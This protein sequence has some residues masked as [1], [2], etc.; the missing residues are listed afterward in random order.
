MEKE[1][2]NCQLLVYIWVSEQKSTLNGKNLPIILRRNVKIMLIKTT[3]K[4]NIENVIWVSFN[5]F[6]FQNIFQYYFVI[7][8]GYRESWGE[9][10]WKKA[11]SLHNWFDHLVQYS[12]ESACST[13]TGSKVCQ[14][15]SNIHRQRPQ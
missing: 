3:A 13:F 8:S 1:E 7:I 6:N 9:N 5:W 11:M 2:K 14:T 10:R 12:I 15:R 4:I